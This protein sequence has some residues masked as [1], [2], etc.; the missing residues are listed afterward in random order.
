MMPVGSFPQPFH[1]FAARLHEPRKPATFVHYLLSGLQQL[2]PSDYSSWT[3][4]IYSKSPKVAAVFLPKNPR[5]TSLLP[6][7]ERHLSEHPVCNYWQKSGHYHVACRWSDVVAWSAIERMPLYIKFYRPLGVRHQMMVALKATPSHLIYLALNRSRTPFSEQDR[8]LLTALQPHAS[9]ALQS[10]LSFQWQQSTLASYSAF[11]D[12]VSQGIVC[13]SPDLHI[14]WANKR[15]RGDLHGHFGWPVNSTR[16]PGELLDQLTREQT[17]AASIPRSF[18][19]QSRTGS[20]H[21]RALKTPRD[22]YLFFPAVEQQP[23]PD[24]LKT[25][26]LTNREA[27]VLGWI[28]R[29]KSNDEA[30]AI[31][32]IGPQTVKKHLERIYSVLGVSNRT[33]AAVK[34]QAVL[35]GPAPEDI[36]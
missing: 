25:F 28:A 1:Q 18:S 13:L 9:R 33:E 12:T 14:R 3:E 29:G 2:I 4:I 8:N 27:E 11:V 30:A 23:V 21:V 24:A 10:T 16:L 6:V 7:F 35:H 5:A 31:L 17:L 36:A 15:A 19:V 20:L 26:G 34:A 22:F 32:G